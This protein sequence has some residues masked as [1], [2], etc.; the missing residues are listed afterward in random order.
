MQTCYR[1]SPKLQSRGRRDCNSETASS[2]RT[3]RMADPWVRA[4]DLRPVFSGISALFQQ[5]CRGRAPICARFFS[6]HC[7]SLFT[8]C[9]SAPKSVNFWPV[10]FGHMRVLPSV[11]FT[12]EEISSAFAALTKTTTTPQYCHSQNGK[13]APFTLVCYHPAAHFATEV[14]MS[15]ARTFMNQAGNFMSQ[16]GRLHEL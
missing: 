15:H 1:N 4:K 8:L 10:L 6:P 5:K 11:F 12:L 7:N 3:A 14:F 9:E 16:A 2:V 13:A